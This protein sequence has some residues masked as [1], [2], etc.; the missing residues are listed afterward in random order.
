MDADSSRD[1][2]GQQTKGSVG[3]FVD[4]DLETLV[5]EMDADDKSQWFKADSC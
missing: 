3:N 1:G 5:D 2:S 4:M